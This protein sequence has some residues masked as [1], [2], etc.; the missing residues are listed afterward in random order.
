MHRGR[1]CALMVLGWACVAT[2]LF[3]HD[4][5][6][7]ESTLTVHGSHVEAVLTIGL[8]DFHK[9][10]DIDQNHDGIVS[11]DE[12]D[13]AIGPLYAA[14][15]EHYTVRSESGV[16]TRTAV[17]RYALLPGGR[18]RL[19]IA[20]QFAGDVRV[21]RVEST[22]DAITQSDHQ[23]LTTVALGGIMHD[24]ILTADAPVSV[25]ENGPRAYVEAAQRFLRLGLTAML[26]G[27]AH[28]AFLIA[29]LISARQLRSA[30]AIVASL[31]I[32]QSLSLVLTAYGVVALPPRLTD[33]LIAA[34]IALV[35]IENLLRT[36]S[37]ARPV[38]TF[39]FSV[40]HGVGLAGVLR[41]LQLPRESLAFATLF[42][43]TGVEAGL[44]ILAGAVFLL[45][46]DLVRSPQMADRIR[47]VL[48]LGA[49]S[50]AM[51]WFLQRGFLS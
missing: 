13:K 20:Y 7:S 2:R 29:L 30:V 1:W 45:L 19:E 35:A 41:D 10:P 14:V 36:E 44:L 23:H 12:L 8:S 18:L 9:L 6:R 21:L 43:G 49:A 17:E 3:A 22:L 38:V 33:G 16:P 5:S 15:R 48:S 39:V 24:A 47:P 42:F 31:T 40:A 32:A 28:L 50:Y 51:Y 37:L 4:I 34:S 11:Y 27:P 25:F 46:R 26:T